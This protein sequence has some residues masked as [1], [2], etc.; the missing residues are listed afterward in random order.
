MKKLFVL[1]IILLLFLLCSCHFSI[2]V[3]EASEPLTTEAIAETETPDTLTQIRQSLSQEF[4]YVVDEMYMNLASDGFSQ[5][6]CQDSS[7]DGSFHFQMDFH[8]WNHFSD[9]DVS[10][11][12]DFYYQYEDNSMACYAKFNDDTPTRML[13]TEDEETD[14]YATKDQIVGAQALLPDYLTDFADAGNQ[15]ETGLHCFTYRLALS[16]ILSDR[17]LLSSYISNV[18]ASY[19]Y[20][21]RPSDDLSVTVT[22]CTDDSMRPI[23]I[24][25]DFSELK[26]YVLS[27]GALS[28]ETAFETDLMY[29]TY[30]FNYNLPQ[31]VSVP[32]SFFPAS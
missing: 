21:Y 30:T 15:T 11:I 27:D 31:S 16:D 2:P 8:Q 19:G 26:P 7:V 10:D 6:V 9:Y 20:T 22:L 23:S 18:C 13:M 1:C 28:G 25:H 5:T 14:L 24:T 4:S 17:T 32:E 29:L 12:K 3:T